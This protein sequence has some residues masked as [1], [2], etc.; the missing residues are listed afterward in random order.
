[1]LPPELPPEGL[2]LWRKSQQR[3]GRQGEHTKQLDRG[4][5]KRWGVVPAAQSSPLALGFGK[6][7]LVLVWRPEGLRTSWAQVLW[8]KPPP[9]GCGFHTFPRARAVSAPLQLRGSI[10][11]SVP[12]SLPQPGRESWPRALVSP[13]QGPGG[14]VGALLSRTHLVCSFGSDTC[15]GPSL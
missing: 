11:P 8:L 12:P 1:M 7:S 5:G 14:G 6:T 9:P 15:P 13:Q 10:T 2:P 4:V 3:E